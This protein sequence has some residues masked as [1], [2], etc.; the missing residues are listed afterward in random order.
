VVNIDLE[1]I[2]NYVIRDGFTMRVLAIEPYYGGS[3]KAFIDGW[4]ARSSHE[5]TLLTMPPRKWKWRMRGSAISFATQVN[6]RYKNGE[7]WDTIFCCDMLN[8]AEFLGL[9][10]KE[11]RAIP[12]VI[13]FHENQITYPNQVE[14]E[15]DFQFGVTNITSCLAADSVWFN[16]QYHRAEFVCA[17]KKIFKKM[18]DFRCLEQLDLI[19][20][21]SVEVMKKSVSC[22]ESPLKIVWAARW[23]HDKNPD[24]FFE[25]LKKLKASGCDFEFSVIGESF[26]SSPDCFDW[27]KDYFAEH[28]CYW[29]YQ[30]SFKGY[31]E[32]LSWGD[33]FVST[34]AH[35]FF[36]LTAVEAA[37]SGTL[38]L[39]PN[40]LAYPEVFEY[41]NPKNK[42]RF[43]Y[44]GSVDGLVAKLREAAQLK[45]GNP[46]SLCAGEIQ[47][48]LKKFS[49]NIAASRLDKSLVN[50]VK[51]YSV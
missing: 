30:E 32:C 2:D 5:W 47:E 6:E 37:M 23:E 45:K 12:L 19:L 51:G 50:F 11:I 39:L 21:K 16:S 3:H 7:R 35:E 41:E 28:I 27:A 18:P 4:I 44:D 29:G 1:F 46:S 33:V 31:C 22:S 26:R 20:E 38:P 36:G 48:S 15:R 17:A 8:V 43:F 24:D 40:R 42:K 14:S 13:Y 49:W 25:A 34:A 10:D 9:I